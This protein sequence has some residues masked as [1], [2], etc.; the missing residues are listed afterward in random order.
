[1]KSDFSVK[2]TS[3]TC[4]VFLLLATGCGVPSDQNPNDSMNEDSYMEYEGERFRTSK[5]Y[6]D[7]DDF[8]E[9]PDN[10]LKSETPRMTDAVQ[11][12]DFAAFASDRE[13]AMKQMFEKQ[14]PGFGCGQ[15]GTLNREQLDRCAAFF[16]EVPR[17]G[18]S[19]YAGYVNV[20]GQFILVSDF[21]APQTPM[22]A[23]VSVSDGYLNFHGMDRSIMRRDPIPDAK[24]AGQ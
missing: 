6:F 18:K 14:F 1:M 11:R 7:W 16:I 8:K 21:V 12:V 20:E 24:D 5:E 13:T 4:R 10:Y 23:M 15:L 19:R 9:D 3:A 17:T 22:I 2:K